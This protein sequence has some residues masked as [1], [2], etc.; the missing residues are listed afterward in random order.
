MKK[1]LVLY[2]ALGAFL[3]ANSQRSDTL[4]LMVYNLLYYGEYTSF[5]TTSNN[6]VVDK[7][8]YLKTIIDHTVPDVFMVNE[9]GSTT[10]YADR[11]LLNCLNQ[12]GRGYYQRANSSGNSFSNLVNMLYYNA[13]KLVYYSQD[14]IHESITGSNLTRY[15]DIYTL[16]YKDEFLANHQDTVFVTFIVA[17]LNASDASKRRVETEAIMAYLDDNNIRGNLILAGDLNVKSSSD[18]EFQNLVSHSNT[19][20]VFRD[21]VNQLG[22]W[23]N[24]STYASV[25]TQS[26]HTS[27]QCYS[28][29]GMDDRFDFMLVNDWVI[30]DSGRVKYV[31]GTYKALGQDGG[32]LNGTLLS[33]ANSSEPSDVLDALYDMSDHLPVLMDIRFDLPKNTGLGTEIAEQPLKISNPVDREMT[34]IW[35]NGSGV[36]FEVNIYNL[37][38]QQVYSAWLLGEQNNINLSDLSAGTYLIQTLNK[39]GQFQSKKIIKL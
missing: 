4:S 20:V 28:G 1:L 2:L 6:N 8:D 12:N 33:P 29:G 14:E 37:Q 11:I 32:R 15:I 23:N 16:Y 34:L 22:N 7:D 26:T 35:P 38:G 39:K 27:G 9:L 5:C 31:D 3:N 30:N 18:T 24:S 21:P 17:H 10:T 36:E 25:H 13:D 19:S